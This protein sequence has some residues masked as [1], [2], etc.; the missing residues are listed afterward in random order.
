MC[1]RFR[2]FPIIIG[3]S[4]QP[5]A[6]VVAASMRHWVLRGAGAWSGWCVPWAATLCANV[7]W[8]DAAVTWLHWWASAF[9]NQGHG[10]LHDAAF[11][12]CSI[13]EPTTSLWSASGGE[14]A[15]E[16]M[17]IEA[18]MGAVTAIQEL[19][20][21]CR[22]GVIAVLPGLPRGWSALDFDG[23]WTEG[24]FRV[25]AT[26]REGRVAEVRIHATR[27]GPLTLV[28]TMRGAWQIAGVVHTGD[29]LAYEMAVGERI[30]VRADPS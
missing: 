15:T 19:L 3:V 21:Q 22:D 14:G 20:V 18:G 4:A 8:A 1:I 5:H 16:V 17:Q 26:V 25:G 29:T 27:G 10:T 6:P 24:G 23:I 7:G 28:H 11:A 12:G 9:T 2:L 13:L 30:V